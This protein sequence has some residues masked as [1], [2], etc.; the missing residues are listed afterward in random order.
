M[1]GLN[2]QPSDYESDA[3]P[4][5]PT[6]LKSGNAWINSV[7]ITILQSHLFFTSAWFSNKAVR[8]LIRS[9][10]RNWVSCHDCICQV[11]KYLQKCVSRVASVRVLYFCN[12]LSCHHLLPLYPFSKWS[13]GF[14]AGANPSC[15]QLIT[16]PPGAIWGS[17][18]CS[19]TLQHAAQLSPKSWDLSLLYLL[20]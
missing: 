16:G 15:R 12:Q 3:L 13:Q 1:W 19:R 9:L 4:T 5:A 20:S 14:V 11:V 2:S 17:V 18:S 10:W 8:P 6:R 7:T